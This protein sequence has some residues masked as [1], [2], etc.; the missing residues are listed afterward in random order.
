LLALIDDGSPSARTIAGCLL[1]R[2]PEALTEL[3][4]ERLTALAQHEVASVRAGAHALI[5]AGAALLRADPSVLFVLVE[6]TWEDTRT[7]AFDLLRNVIDAAKLGLEG[8]LGLLD[9]NRV[10]VQNVGCELVRRHFAELPAAELV[11][12][13]AQHPHPNVRR[14]ALDLAVK[15]LPAGPEALARLRDFFRAALFDLWPE[16]KVKRQVLDFLVA[17][18]LGDEREARVAA[19]ILG[20]AVRLQGRADFERALEGLV[21]LQLAYPDVDTAVVVRAGGEP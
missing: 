20:D 19:A 16:R 6:S 8:F 2:H 10:D 13:L 4:L 3:G 21:R 17:R 9:S 14:F 15:H 12:R 1:G 18:G 7:L 5:R 11:Y